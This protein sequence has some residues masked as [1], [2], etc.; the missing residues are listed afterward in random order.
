M[1]SYDKFKWLKYNTSIHTEYTYKQN[2]LHSLP[3]VSCR[4]TSA[5][6]IIVMTYLGGAC[7]EMDKETYIPDRLYSYVSIKYVMKDF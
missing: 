5:A 3:T 7:M 2:W 4:R 1:N 6:F